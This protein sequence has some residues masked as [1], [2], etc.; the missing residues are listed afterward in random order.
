M[1]ADN[2]MTGGGWETGIGWTK[3]GIRR[4]LRD[5]SGLAEREAGSERFGN[6]EAE[7]GRI[8]A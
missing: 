8:Q 7:T 1:R 5:K 2:V 4:I 6:G 3:A